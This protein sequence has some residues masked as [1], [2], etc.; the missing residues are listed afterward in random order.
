[1][2]ELQVVRWIDNFIVEQGAPLYHKVDNTRGSNYARSE[3]VDLDAA[4]TMKE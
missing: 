1:M 4:E 2:E 3:S